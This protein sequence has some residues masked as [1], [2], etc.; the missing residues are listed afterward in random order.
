MISVQIDARNVSMQQRAIPPVVYLDQWAL[1]KIAEESH[2]RFTEVLVRRG[3]TLALSVL[4]LI[5][6]AKMSRR[7]TREGIER[8]LASVCPHLCFIQPKAGRVIDQENAL[9]TGRSFVAPQ[10]DDAFLEIFVLRGRTGRDYRGLNPTGLLSELREGGPL[11]EQIGP[12]VEKLHATFDE[13]LTRRRERYARDAGARHRVLRPP[14]GPPRPFPTRFLFEELLDSLVRHR[15]TMEPN[16]WMDFWHSV[17]P[18]SYCDFVLLDRRWHAKVTEACRRL[19]RSGL[20]T[21]AAQ[22]FS[23][24]TMGEFWAAFDT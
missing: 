13:D 8:L 17:V 12:I 19:R 7:P 14:K 11:D 6:S 24:R 1:R 23:P 18:V 4:H 16:D 20:I 10:F 15:M 2:Q 21:R 3:G 9:L 22:V 5:E